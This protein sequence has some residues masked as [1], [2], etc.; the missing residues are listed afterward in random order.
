[1]ERADKWKSAEL[2]QAACVCLTGR[3]GPPLLI[4]AKN[5]MVPSLSSLKGGFDVIVQGSFLPKGMTSLDVVL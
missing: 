2:L 3:P 5:D 4:Y 1:M